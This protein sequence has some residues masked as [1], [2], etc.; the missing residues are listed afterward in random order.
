S[1]SRWAKGPAFTVL[2]FTA[3]GMH[4]LLK[5]F[6]ALEASRRLNEDRRSGAL[7]LL[8]VTPLSLRQII[9]GQALAL[10]KMFI[11]AMAI[12]VMVNIFM[13]WLVGGPDP[14]HSGG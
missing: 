14:V 6:I 2:M 10:R 7:E 9:S 11:S 4:F 3:F 5:V 12:V 13:L 1:S 8:L